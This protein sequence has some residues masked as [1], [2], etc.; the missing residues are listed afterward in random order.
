MIIKDIEDTKTQ[1]QMTLK[2]D[3]IGLKKAAHMAQ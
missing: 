2:K 3:I 1:R